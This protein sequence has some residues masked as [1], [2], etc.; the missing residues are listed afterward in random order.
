MLGGEVGGDMLLELDHV[1]AG[2]LLCVAGADQG[3][4]IGVDD[5]HGARRGQSGGR[6]AE[7]ALHVWCAVEGGLQTVMMLMEERWVQE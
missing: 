7:K 5:H 4:G 3:R 2:D 6:K 1:A